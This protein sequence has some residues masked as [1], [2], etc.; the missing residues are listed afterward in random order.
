MAPTV[1]DLDAYRTAWLLVKEY[2]AAVP[3]IAAKRADALLEL[4]DLA[5][6]P[7]W[8]GILHAVEDLRNTSPTGALQ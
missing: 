8:R 3:L 5:G 7:V 4:G 1:S 6:S 2:G